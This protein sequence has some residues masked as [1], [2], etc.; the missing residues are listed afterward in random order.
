M[1][2]NYLLAFIFGGLFYGFIILMAHASRSIHRKWFFTIPIWP[3]TIVILLIRISWEG[4]K[5]TFG[6]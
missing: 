1:M 5:V 2:E 3:L 6:R 4:V